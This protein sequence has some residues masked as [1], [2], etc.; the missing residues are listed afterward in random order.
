MQTV[1]SLLTLPISIMSYVTKQSSHYSSFHGQFGMLLVVL[2]LVQG[3]L[4]SIVHY[5]SSHVFGIHMSPQAEF[6][7]R[8]SKPHY[9]SSL[10][11]PY[12]VLTLIAVH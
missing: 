5:H 3:Y 8:K 4:G 9:D 10:Q 1:A 7:F 6:F 2:S 11:Q 12:S